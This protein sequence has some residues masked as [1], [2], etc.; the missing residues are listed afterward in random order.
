MSY[1]VEQFIEERGLNR[2][3]IEARKRWMEADIRAYELKEKQ[4]RKHLS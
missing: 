1:S 3:N 2:A 4:G